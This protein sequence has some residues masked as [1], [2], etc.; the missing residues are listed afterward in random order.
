MYQRT[1]IINEQRIVECHS[2]VW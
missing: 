2:C 1:P